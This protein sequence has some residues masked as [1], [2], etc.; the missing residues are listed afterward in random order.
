MPTTAVAFP[1]ILSTCW[2][3]QHP[4]IACDTIFADQ[5]RRDLIGHG[6]LGHF[7]CSTRSSFFVKL[8]LGSELR[9]HLLACLCIRSLQRSVGS[10]NLRRRRSDRCSIELVLKQH[11]H[12]DRQL[13]AQG[14]DLHRHLV[15]A[16]HE[17]CL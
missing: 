13:L 1:Q 5:R 14:A 4:L 3:K 8:L 10:L 2:R 15:Q 6:H 12:R 9:S 16:V 7:F 17:S 11:V